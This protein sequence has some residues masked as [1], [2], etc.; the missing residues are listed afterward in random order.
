[1]KPI[2]YIPIFLLLFVSF[3]SLSQ[4]PSRPNAYDADSLRTGE[5]LVLYDSAGEHEVFEIADA[6]TYCLVNFK[7]NLPTNL[8]E[9]FYM[10]GIKQFEGRLLSFDPLVKHGKVLFFH[11][12]GLVHQDV[13]F[14]YDS[15]HGPITIYHDNGLVESTGEMVNNK[16]DGYWEYFYPNGSIQMTVSFENGL[17]NGPFSAYD[18]NGNLL[19]E[20]TLKNGKNHGDWKYY[21]ASGEL[22]STAQWEND[23]LVGKSVFYYPSG[24]LKEI[25]YKKNGEL[26]GHITSYY[27]NGNKKSES[28]YNEGKRFGKATYYH[29]NGHIESTGNLEEDLYEGKWTYYHENGKIASSGLY[30]EDQR[31]GHW[32]FYN[33]SGFITSEGYLEGGLWEGWARLYDQNG[34][35]TSTGTYK[36]DLKDGC[37]EY[38]DGGLLTGVKYFTQD[39]LDGSYDDYYPSG[40]LEA[41]GKLTSGNMDSLFLFY[42][43]NGHLSSAERYSNGVLNGESTTYYENGQIKSQGA[44]LNGNRHGHTRFFFENGQLKSEGRYEEGSIEGPWTYYHPNGQVSSHGEYINN[45]SQGYWKYYYDDG[46][47]KNEGLEQE[48]NRERHWIYYYPNGHK[49][50]EGLFTRDLQDSLWTYYKEDGSFS[51]TS[52]Y[53]LGKALNFSTYYDS[54]TSLADAGQFKAA[55]EIAKIAKKKKEEQFNKDHYSYS[56]VYSLYD[57]LYKKEGNYKKAIKMSKKAVKAA[58]TS[59]PDTSSWVTANLNSLAARYL[60]AR[61]YQKALSTAKELMQ[62]GLQT[63]A[64][65]FSK[66]YDQGLYQYTETL[67]NMGQ[68]TEALH[69]YKDFVEAQIE[70]D[71]DSIVI[72]ENALTLVQRAYNIDSNDYAV[73][74]ATFLID[75]SEKKGITQHYTYPLAQYHKAKIIMTD[76]YDGAIDIL[77]KSIWDHYQANDTTSNQFF[78]TL[79]YLGN[80]YYGKALL[81]SAQIFFNEALWRL[82]HPFFS[83]S[84]LRPKMLASSAK[85]VYLLNDNATAKA[86]YE[87]ALNLYKKL[88]EPDPYIMS[89]AYQGLALIAQDAGDQKLTEQYFNNALSVLEHKQDYQMQYANT[90]LLY[91]EYYEEMN[92]YDKALQ[93]LN[94]LDAYRTRFPKEENLGVASAHLRGEVYYEL[95]QFDSAIHYFQLCVDLAKDDPFSVTE[96]AEALR[97]IADVYEDRNQDYVKAQTYNLKSLHLLDSTIGKNN[98]PYII[99]LSE[100]ARNFEF[101]RQ[102]ATAINYL[103][104]LIEICPNIAGNK[105]S[106]E[107][108]ARINLGKNLRKNGKVSEAVKVLKEAKQSFESNEFTYS[109]EYSSALRELAYCYEEEPFNDPLSA[110]KLLLAAA[111]VAENYYGE[112]N[113]GHASALDNLSYFYTRTYDYAQAKKYRLQSM[114]IVEKS[115]G[116]NRDY[117]TDLKALSSIEYH[118]GN[119]PIAINLINEAI[120]IYAGLDLGSEDYMN[121]VYSRGEYL[122]KLGQFQ[123]AIDGYHKVLELV[124]K[125]YGAFSYAV[126][127]PYELI[128]MTYYRWKKP[129]KAMKYL[130]I[131]EALYDSLQA[132]PTTYLEV[133]NMKGLCLTDLN[134]HEE[135]K[136]YFEKALNIANELWPDDP[137]ASAV[138]RNNLAFYYLIIGEFATA[139]KL[140][141]SAESIGKDGTP[142]QQVRWLDNMAT[143]YQSWGKMDEAATYWQQTLDILFDKIETDFPY[144]SEEGKAAFWDAYKEDFEYFNSYATKAAGLGRMNALRDMYDNHIRTKSL[145]LSTSTKERQRILSSGDSTLIALYKEYLGLKEQLAKYY[146]YTKERLAEEAINLKAVETNINR[147]EKVLSMDAEALASAQKESK[148]RW[149]DVQRSLQPGE[150]AIEIIRYRQFDR[151]VTDSV[152]YAALILT[153]DTR[154]QPALVT[155]GNGY[156]LETKYLKAYLSSIKYQVPDQYSYSQFWQPINEQL[157]GIETLYLSLDGVYNQ[158]SLGSIPFPDGSYLLDHYDV[159]LVSST[160]TIPSLKNATKKNFLSNIGYLFG[161]PKYDL[162]HESIELELKERGITTAPASTERATDMRNFSFAELPGTRDETTG[163]Y[164]LLADRKWEMNL[165]LQNEALEEEL[166]RVSNPRLLHIATHGFFLEDTEESSNPMQLGINTET[167]RNNP[168]LRSGLLMAGATQTAQGNHLEGIENGVF[169]AYEAMNLDL[170]DTELVVL[171]AC[172]TGRGEIKNG[173]GVYGLQRAFQIAGAEAIVMSLWKVDDRATQ[174]LMN[175]FYDA[176]LQNQSKAQALKTAQMKVR[177]EFANPYYWGAFVL[178]E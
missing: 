42:Y 156:E 141:L 20:G 133:F 44:Y 103:N 171:S 123:E 170:T 78:E 19:K 53:H 144:L 40:R 97:G 150:A 88:V 91:G 36:N 121:A 153:P 114:E 83:E 8:V 13:R 165:Y 177:R 59:Q 174:L 167:S 56:D 120:D 34:T 60:N 10:D 116:K 119:Y 30:H 105:L 77:Q 61:D 74:M 37:W 5:W 126:S 79:N 63:K 175:S 65:I 54:A 16:Q 93:R 6:N 23:L 22:K 62:I 46:T 73:K 159:R 28:T 11:P 15:L 75:Y 176:W 39:V 47:L 72:A 143:L 71:A 38:Y 131:T 108:F 76:D 89:M 142:I 68:K 87:E 145:L 147:M 107:L 128:A 90:L 151:V 148:I 58:R 122:E 33:D 26:H 163:I 99:T 166:K 140:W 50:M 80:F 157:K 31:V 158:I 96:A 155:L 172:E 117:A 132:K 129:D 137:D 152:I 35:L 102:H 18:L 110:E 100:I 27:E 130:N 138:Y 24:E 1:M 43:P 111:E 101:Q 4:I 7:E 41:S 173:E 45:Q 64:G 161:Y 66:P 48:D 3:D 12:N 113:M 86:Q 67:Q 57:Y 106:Y 112:G 178:V 134:R 69:E 154:N 98:I 81:D 104:Q 70:R 160:K 82:D 168:L 94:Q 95:Q 2:A 92:K 9:C 17:A 52:M 139:E 29:A 125:R 146:G 21:Y 115:S 149:K 109:W 169:T 51:S 25:N 84:Y 118:L 127:N 14:A 162:N 124:E 85:N 135:S 32:R 49:E 136:A 55:F 164:D